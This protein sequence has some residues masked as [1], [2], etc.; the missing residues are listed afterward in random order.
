MIGIIVQL[1][2]SS[3]IILLYEKGD[4]GIL[5]FRPTKKRGRDFLLFFL[6]TAACAASGFLLKIIIA[7]QS[8]ILNPDINAPLILEGVWFTLKSVLFEELIF[9]GVLLYILIR[10]IGATKAIL[11]SAAAFGVYHWFSH[12]LWGNPMLMAIE[13][14]ITGTMGLV[15]AYGYAKSFSL[16][17]PI[18]IHFGWNFLQ[19]VVFSGNTIGNQFFVEALPRPVVTI[20]YFSYFVILLLPV[21]SCWI[22]NTLMLKKFKQV[23]R[24]AIL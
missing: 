19:M 22:I 5:G 13:F 10:K 23:R 17:I 6:I 9:R 3:L 1:A 21:F 12:E 24:P 14:L 16:Y 8:W 15:L 2:I 20:S 18:A 11:I 4:L 7:K